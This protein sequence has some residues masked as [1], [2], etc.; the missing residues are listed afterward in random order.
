MRASLNQAL[1]RPWAVLHTRQTYD[2][3]LF[4]DYY[5]KQTQFSILS[6]L[7]FKIAYG[8]KAAQIEEI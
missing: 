8:K 2:L 7:A 5:K 3:K 4:P 6:A 1:A